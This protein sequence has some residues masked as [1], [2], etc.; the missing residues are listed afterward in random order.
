MAEASFQSAN[1]NPQ[2]LP[3]TTVSILA[4]TKL[5]LKYINDYRP[6]AALLPVG[7]GGLLYA[8]GRCPVFAQ[9]ASALLP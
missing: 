6:K 4:H 7:L 3:P 5:L 1:L 9:A 2:T 8:V